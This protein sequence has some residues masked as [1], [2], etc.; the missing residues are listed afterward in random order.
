MD[1]FEVYSFRYVYPLRPHMKFS[2]ARIFITW[3]LGENPHLEYIHCEYFLKIFCQRFERLKEKD[4]KKLKMMQFNKNAKILK[5]FLFFNFVLQFYLL[6]L[7][8]Y[9]I[10]LIFSFLSFSLIILSS[11]ITQLCEKNS[12]KAPS[13]DRF[14]PFEPLCHLRWLI[15]ARIRWSRTNLVDQ[16]SL[17]NRVD[18]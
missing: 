11:L 16:W 3:S 13:F 8:L 12:N 18:W 6:V 15:L 10:S 9:P 2:S 4:W 7:Q 5:H 14:L 1:T 17:T